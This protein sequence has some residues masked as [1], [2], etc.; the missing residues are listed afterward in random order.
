MIK[1]HDIL[2]MNKMQALIILS[3]AQQR[4]HLQEMK[5]KIVIF[6]I[7]TQLVRLAIAKMCHGFN[8][9][10]MIFVSAQKWFSMNKQNKFE[11]G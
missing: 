5:Q 9:E 11:G 3:A 4:F 6:S 1:P 10:I 2:N 8:K 7:P